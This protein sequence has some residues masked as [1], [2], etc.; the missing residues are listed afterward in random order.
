MTKEIQEL[1]QEKVQFV[2]LNRL[3]G[4]DYLVVIMRRNKILSDYQDAF[5]RL[6]VRHK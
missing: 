4:S 2:I 1:I 3:F 5:L 6:M